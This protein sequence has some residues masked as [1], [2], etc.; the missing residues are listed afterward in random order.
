MHAEQATQLPKPHILA[1][2]SVHARIVLAHVI[3]CTLYIAAA[4]QDSTRPCLTPADSS[5]FCCR[6]V[7][8]CTCAADRPSPLVSGDWCEPFCPPRR[9]PYPSPY[10]NAGVLGRGTICHDALC[11]SD[12]CQVCKHIIVCIRIVSN[13][14]YNSRFLCKHSSL[15][16]QMLYSAFT[17]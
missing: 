11:I 10:S 9:K 17:V 14:A 5:R 6:P 1:L 15:S 8:G 4:W 13:C 16:H 2:H 7:W 12:S 3:V